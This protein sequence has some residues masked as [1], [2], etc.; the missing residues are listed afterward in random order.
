[1][2]TVRVEV[3]VAASVD[4]VWRVL[5]D[6]EAYPGLVENVQ[7]VE[8]LSE[9]QDS[10]RTSA[11]SVRLEGSVL[12]WT[13]REQIDE[14]RHAVTFDQL[15]GDLRLFSGT[16]SVRQRGGEKTLVTLEVEFDIGI[17][18]LAELLNPVAA[19]ALRSNFE[20]ILRYIERSVGGP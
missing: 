5:L 3:S 13:E 16:W 7:A 1:M 20:Y 9:S 17:P 6:I 14:H 10:T 2:P 18:L 11:W 4:A 19:D 12:E 8:V 15:D